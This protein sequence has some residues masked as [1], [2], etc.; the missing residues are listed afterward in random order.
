METMPSVSENAVI[1]KRSV[2]GVWVVGIDG[3]PSSRHAALWAAG[4]VTG[5][6]TELHLV[7]AW[8]APVLAPTAAWGGHPAATSEAFEKHSLEQVERLAI[9][10]RSSTADVTVES[11]VCRGGA[12]TILLDAAGHASL[13]VV[14]SRG[15]GGFAR[16]MLGSTSTQCATHA[17]V[18]TAVIPRSAPIGSIRRIVVAIDGSPNSLA[19][20]RWA[21]DFAAAGTVIECVTVWDVTPLV[22]SGESFALPEVTERARRQFAESMHELRRST[23]RRDLTINQH[24]EEG[25]PRSVLRHSAQDCDL[26]VMG[27]HGQGAIGSMLLGSVSSWLLHHVDRP[28]VVVPDSTDVAV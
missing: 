14:G 8:H 11:I 7:T 18:A 24:F 15:R 2:P 12:A 20:A 9:E 5:R 10:I 21:V 27:A 28:I 13:L 22:T 4:Q 23:G 1:R 3:S 16:L 17:S 25:L 19:A 6:S 26:F